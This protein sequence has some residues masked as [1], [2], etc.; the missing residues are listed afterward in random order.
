VTDCARWQNSATA[1]M[2]FSVRKWKSDGSKDD[3]SA[4]VAYPLI[5]DGTAV[6]MFCK[7]SGLSPGCS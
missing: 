4:P 2:L 6:Q 1:K 3:P 7:P 5:P